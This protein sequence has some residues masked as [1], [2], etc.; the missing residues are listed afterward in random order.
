MK[1]TP[2]I[3]K[4]K[5]KGKQRE[6]ALKPAPPDEPQLL[7]NLSVLKNSKRS[8]DPIGRSELKIQQV[9]HQLNFMQKPPKN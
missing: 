6:F 4:A 1:W 2:R 5:I 7:F 3:I 8:G 9:K